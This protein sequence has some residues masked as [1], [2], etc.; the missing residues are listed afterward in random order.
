MKFARYIFILFIFVLPTDAFATNKIISKAQ[1]I[2]IAKEKISP[3]C[4]N[5]DPCIV[6]ATKEKNHWLVKLQHALLTKSGLLILE[7]GN[8][9]IFE[10]NDSGKIVSIVPGK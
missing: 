2:S 4:A 5:S 1:A 3:R 10:I 9:Q 6:T 8:Y 7:V